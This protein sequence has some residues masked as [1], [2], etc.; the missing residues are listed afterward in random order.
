MRS[1]ECRCISNTDCYRYLSQQESNKQ[2]CAVKVHLERMFNR[3][4]S[5]HATNF[6]PINDSSYIHHRKPTII[7]HNICFMILDLE[8]F[9]TLSPD[10]F[11]F[12]PVHR[13]IDRSNVPC[14]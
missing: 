12:N 13:Y 4:S 5:F 10:Y 2:E 6:L 8:H 9:G 14:F 1:L 11:F 7:C 3:Y